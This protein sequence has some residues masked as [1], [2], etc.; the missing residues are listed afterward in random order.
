MPSRSGGLIRPHHPTF[1][2]FHRMLDSAIVLFTLVAARNAYDGD[3]STAY[4]FA[5]L[6]AVLGLQAAGEIT[7]RALAEL[8]RLLYDLSTRRTRGASVLGL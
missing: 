5:G 7:L 8:Q 3:M 6:L 4:W 1:A 2:L